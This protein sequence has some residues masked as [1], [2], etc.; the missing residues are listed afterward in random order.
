SWRTMMQ[1]I[2]G[3]DVLRSD[4]D[5]AFL[6]GGFVDP[7]GLPSPVDLLDCEDCDYDCFMCTDGAWVCTSACTPGEE[8]TAC[9][10]DVDYGDEDCWKWP[11][12][13]EEPSGPGGG[14]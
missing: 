3:F 1:G 12:L 9:I 5:R 13:P 10:E 8:A 6:S 14:V 2:Y 11:D 4:N 7:V